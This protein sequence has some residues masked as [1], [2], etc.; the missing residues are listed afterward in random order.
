MHRHLPRRPTDTCGV[1]G[2]VGRTRF[3]ISLGAPRLMNCTIAFS[4]DRANKDAWPAP[5]H[6]HFQAYK[7]VHIPMKTQHTAREARYN[8][9]SIQVGRAC[10]YSS[11]VKSRSFSVTEKSASKGAICSLRMSSCFMRNSCPSIED[12]LLPTDR[13]AICGHNV[14]FRQCIAESAATLLKLGHFTLGS[15]AN[16]TH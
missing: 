7:Q 2:W 13:A 14:N 12:D 11:Q 3:S 8:C 1:K 10:K 6:T 16:I 15:F 4:E 9:I 5:E